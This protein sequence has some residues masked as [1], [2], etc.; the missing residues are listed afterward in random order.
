[1][2]NIKSN[3][4]SNMIYYQVPKWLMNLFI[5]KKISQGAFK[6]Y[7]LMYDRLKLSARNKWIDKNGDVYIKYS[8]DEMTEDLN[9]SRQAVSNNLQDLEKLYLIDKKR[10]FSSS[11]TFYLKIYSV[12]NDSSEENLDCHSYR[13]LDCSSQENLDCSSQENLDSNNNNFNKNNCSNNKEKKNDDYRRHSQSENIQ[14]KEIENLWREKGLR[15]FE[16]PPVEDINK[17]IKEFSLV[18]VYQAIERI[19][20]SNYWKNRVGIGTFFKSDNNFEWIRDTL[21]GDRDD[22]KTQESGTAN[23]TVSVSYDDLK[24]TFS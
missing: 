14:T 16:Y 21:N 9:C 18:K 8:Y 6:T 3:D 19:S 22:F 1:M 15:D 12:E 13:K 7:I 4:L 23:Q 24:N 5:V 2:R 20:K 11:S 17:A 10:N